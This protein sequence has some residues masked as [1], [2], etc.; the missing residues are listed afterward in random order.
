[1]T[2]PPHDPASGPEP[3]DDRPHGDRE[4]PDRPGPYG[5]RQPYGERPQGQQPPY[6]EQPPREG[7]QPYGQQP[8]GE[9]QYGQQPP[10][11][12]QQY[13]QQPYGEQQWGGQQY[14]GQQPYGEQQPYGQQP[15]GEQGQWQQQPYG[16]QPYGAQPGYGQQHPGYGAGGYAHPSGELASRWARLG[17]GI[18]DLIIIGIVTGLISIPFVNWNNVVD[19]EPGTS[20][21]NG[22]QVGANA[23]SV[24]LAFFYFWLM[25]ARWGQT[26]GKMLVR[27]RV[28]RADDGQA[29]TTGQAAGRSAFYSVLG[30]I[31]GC[32]G[33]IDIAWILWDQRKQALHCKV[34]RTV[35]VKAD[36][37][38]PNPYAHR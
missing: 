31:C 12:Q 3:E 13:G 22:A 28:V 18:V 4:R 8:Y 9:Q 15:Y 36:P 20:M 10:G 7:R 27:T 26:L 14:G 29:I 33:L 17:G 6:G 30:G 11:G 24:L 21:Y 32:V 37:Y 25:H 23:V 5:G 19:P 38:R 34:A 2:Q 16:E 1:M 35:V